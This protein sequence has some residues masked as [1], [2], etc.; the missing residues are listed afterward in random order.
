[1]KTGRA[2]TG[3][4]LDIP[5][6]VEYTKHFADRFGTD[7]GDRP[8]VDRY[9]D[10]P[11]VLKVIVD[12]LPEIVSNW[13]KTWDHSG[14]ITSRGRGLNMSFVTDTDHDGMKLVMKNM[15]LK[16]SYHAHPKDYVFAVAGT[17]DMELGVAAADHL[18]SM[19]GS[20]MSGRMETPEAV[21]SVDKQE[22][23]LRISGAAWKYDTYVYKVR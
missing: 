9:M 4:I 6:R 13:K 16:P 1:M 17:R 19:A 10:E 8:A 20:R 14:V 12:A 2:W 7:E 23:G 22:R 21:F 5:V 11:E 18:A 15:M 3:T